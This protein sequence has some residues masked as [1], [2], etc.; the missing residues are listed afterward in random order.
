MI[1]KKGAI[2]FSMTTIMVVII[3]VAVLALGLAWIRSTF[4]QVGGI[5]ESSLE[6][7]ETVIGEVAFSG[8]VGAPATINM[9][10]N[11][12]KKFRIL[13]RD[14]GNDPTNGD[15]METY[16]VKAIGDSGTCIELPGENNVF[17]ATL[18][19]SLKIGKNEVAEVGG[20]VLSTACAGTEIIRIE[21]SD[22]D[23]LYATQAIAVQVT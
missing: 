10:T 3:G 22:G 6:A 14:D 2:E 21:V 19:T 12:A 20:A 9:K 1:S 8:K 13:I 18:V 16:S 5:T 4:E 15:P 23:G 11:D 17:E 7:A